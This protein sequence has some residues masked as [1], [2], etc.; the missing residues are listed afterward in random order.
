M[1]VHRDMNNIKRR[2]SI[3]RFFTTIVVGNFRVC[4]VFENYRFF[5][6]LRYISTGFLIST[7]ILIVFH[8]AANVFQFNRAE[9][10]SPKH[11]PTLQ[12]IPIWYVSE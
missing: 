12:H 2:Y 6:R 11:I 10:A 5:S 3:T 9:P 1:R 4:I 8:N 7:R